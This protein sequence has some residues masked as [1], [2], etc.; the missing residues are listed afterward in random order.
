MSDASVEALL[1]SPLRETLTTLDINGC[2]VA[3]YQGE[4]E[5]KEAFPNLVVTVFHS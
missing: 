1:A 4:E 5:L 2:A 3:K